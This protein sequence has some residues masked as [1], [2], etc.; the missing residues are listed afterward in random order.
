[1]AERE[2]LMARIIF[3][4]IG[5]AAKDFYWFHA[6]GTLPLRENTKTNSLQKPPISR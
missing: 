6:I 1:M 4:P 2:Q 5:L 3:D